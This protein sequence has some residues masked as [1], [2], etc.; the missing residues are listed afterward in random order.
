M[1]CLP[2]AQVRNI[3]IKFPGLVQSPDYYPLL[4]VQAGSGEAAE[5]NLR[6]IKRDLE[7]LG[8]LLDQAAAQMFFSITSVVARDIE[9]IIKTHLLNIWRLVQSQE[10]CWVFF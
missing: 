9:R 4:L 6:A 10:F 2:K 8:Q 3:T 1:Y 5:E 7:V